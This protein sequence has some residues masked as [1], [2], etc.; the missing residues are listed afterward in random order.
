MS[1]EEILNLPTT[2][3]NILVIK[4]YLQECSAE[5][6]NELFLFLLKKYYELDNNLSLITEVKGA[7]SKLTEQS[8]INQE[9]LELAIKAALKLS[10]YELA[11]SFYYLLNDILDFNNLYKS[12][13][14]KLI[15]KKSQGANY[16]F[17]LDELLRQHL[18]DEIRINTLYEKLD[19]LLNK[20]N[21]LEAINIINEL[22]KMQITN[23]L[24]PTTLKVLLALKD[25]EKIKDIASLKI[26]QKEHLF[27]SY[28][29]LMI[30]ALNLSDYKKAFIYE[31]EAKAEIS[32]SNDPDK[33]LFYKTSFNLYDS[34][35]NNYLKTQYEKSYQELFAKIEKPDQFILEEE[36]VKIKE[37]VILNDDINEYEL[38]I[39]LG[40]IDFINDH[41]VKF[42]LRTL[43]RTIF[44]YLED[45]I[46]I[47]KALLYLAPNNIY[48]Y[49]KERLYDK[50]I[51]YDDLTNS[52]LG[53]SVK[54]NLSKKIILDNNTICPYKQ[55]PFEENFAQIITIPLSCDGVYGLLIDKNQKVSI[56]LAQGIAKLINN[57]IINF[58]NNNKLIE[59]D[60]FINNIFNSDLF[61]YRYLSKKN[62]VL[63]KAAQELL[64]FES[65][66]FLENFYKNI[67]GESL[68]EYKKL[69]SFLFKKT[70]KLV[71]IEYMYLGKIIKERMISLDLDGEVVIIS[72]FNDIT[73][74]SQRLS[75]LNEKAILDKETGIY[76]QNYLYENYL[77]YLKGKQTF[78]LIE[79]D[80]TN[81]DLYEYDKYISYIK[82]FANITNQFF[83]SGD[84][85]RLTYNEFLLILPF[86]D[87]RTINKTLQDY[88]NYL[89]SYNPESINNELYKVYCASLRYPVVSDSKNITKLI[90]YLQIAK[91]IAKKKIISRYHDFSFNDYET[92]L[93]EQNVINYINEAIN[94]NQFSL[95]FIPILNSEKMIAEGYLAELA[96]TNVELESDYLLRIAS[97]RGRLEAIEYELIR[98]VFVFLNRFVD[99]ANLPM[100]ITIPISDTTFFSANFN[101]YLFSK[102]S[103]YHIDPGFIRILIRGN[104]IKTREFRENIEVLQNAAISIDSENLELAKY[105]DL[106]NVFLDG[107]ALDDKKSLYL[108]N[109]NN[110]L[111]ALNIG[112]IINNIGSK[113]AYDKIK[114]LDFKYLTGPL[115]DYL[116]EEELLEK[117]L[118][119]VKKMAF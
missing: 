60:N 73:E 2:R 81:K 97:K 38:N 119:D 116:S 117:F 46:Q 10:D 18:P 54:E 41:L 107:S 82:E 103:E 42:D 30:V 22:N 95:N 15:I 47:T 24:Y 4:S 56:K 44:I 37:E 58:N 45:K 118:N 5:D 11:N 74:Y 71:A 28:L 27:I 102:I 12:S 111:K 110:F 108:I 49:Y 6:F 53:L 16:A 106:N 32:N 51:D 70:N 55:V 20:E 26:K 34:I 109:I 90:R 3:E 115:F 13:L 86:N 93:F 35:G 101:D 105:Y 72:L 50:A 29:Y 87:I 112:V 99:Y 36:P 84:L 9:I 68:F 69:I 80:I 77:D 8:I 52:V 94:N 66:I 21:Y 39:L 98:K 59:K 92:D 83:T 62:T 91:V 19:Y 79:L 1:K 61:C 67:K 7:L 25:Y 63:N 43:L 76:N 75:Q 14:Y 17:E 100:K 23:N 57:V 104:K 113:I 40:L 88:I 78:L 65:D 31:A 33:L 96:L 114:E 89:A 48:M 64:G 85:F